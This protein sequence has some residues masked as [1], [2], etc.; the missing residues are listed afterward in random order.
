MH[1]RSLRL[2]LAL[3]AL[4]LALR[5]ALAPAATAITPV[6]TGAK[7]PSAAVHTVDGLAVELASVLAGKPTVLIFYRGSWCPYCN[8]H[9]AALAEIEPQLRELGY[10]IVA[11]SPDETAGLQA[12]AAKN[13]LTYRLL[14]D[15]AMAAASAF[16]V[17]FR[18]DAAGVASYH[19]YGIELTPVP[20]EPDAR[21]LP[22]P[23]VF[24]I[25][26]AG[27]VRF[28]HTNPDFKVRLSGEEVLAAAKAAR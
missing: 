16:G 21:W 25:D 10:Q 17:A 4:P 18:V 12:M 7:A 2:L 20:G 15:H 19:G 23:S 28:A 11:I 26:P 3:F 5:A 27:V 9:L 6:K 14:S 1:L 13:H 8:R 24:I 22:V